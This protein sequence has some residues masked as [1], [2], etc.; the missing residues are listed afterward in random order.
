M[1]L[2]IAKQKE[3]FSYSYSPAW[4]S[5]F[6]EPGELGSQSLILLDQLCRIQYDSNTQ[7]SER[8]IMLVWRHE[9]ER[10]AFLRN[11][12]KEEAFWILKEMPS[13]IAVPT[14]RS[15]FPGAWAALLDPSFKPNP[16]PKNRVKELTEILLKSK[17]LNDFSALEGYRQEKDLLDY[18]LVA[19]LS[20]EKDIY[21]AI[22]PDSYL[23]QVR[24]PF[25]Q[26]LESSL[27]EIKQIFDRVTLDEWALALFNVSRDHRR[28]I[29]SLFNSKQ[30]FLFLSKMRTI[31]QAGFDKKIGGK[32]REKISHL[33]QALKRENNMIPDNNEDSQQNESGMDNE[34]SAA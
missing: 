8:L 1:E 12:P 27:E 18:L 33:H 26:V 2:P 20:E 24:P 31:D 6:T 11:I 21:G 29:E 19:S 17:P 9:M 7:E 4:L 10:V 22:S 25:Y 13:S 28:P 23:W 3:V 32:I 14:A 5:A 30:K 15:A 16:I 34:E